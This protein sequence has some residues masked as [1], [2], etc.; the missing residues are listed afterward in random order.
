MKA[1]HTLPLC[2]SLLAQRV[3]CIWII[4]G[5]LIINPCTHVAKSSLAP[6]CSSLQPQTKKS[7]EQRVQ[8]IHG[9]CV[10]DALMLC[11]EDA[12]KQRPDVCNECFTLLI[13]NL[14]WIFNAN[15]QYR[16]CIAAALFYQ[17]T[18]Q[19]P[20]VCAAS[21]VPHANEVM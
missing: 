16:S 2:F 5:F 6:D 13:L 14:M 4:E 9:L 8:I 11:H 7:R 19:L 1:C 12:F 20:Y 10:F 18:S 15:I 3:N 21:A 17:S